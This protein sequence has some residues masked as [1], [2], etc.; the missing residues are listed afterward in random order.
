MQQHEQQSPTGYIKHL[1]RIQNCIVNILHKEDMWHVNVY[2]IFKSSSIT[3]HENKCSCNI[4]CSIQV[5][6]NTKHRAKIADITNKIRNCSNNMHFKSNCA[7]HLCNI[8][9]HSVARESF[10]VLHKQQR[11]I[12]YFFNNS[13]CLLTAATDAESGS[14]LGLSSGGQKCDH[15]DWTVFPLEY[16]KAVHAVWPD[17]S[18]AVSFR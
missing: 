10:A 15:P 14:G 18:K 13:I 1:R 12:I 5:Q 2:H 7:V 16:W 17:M 6:Y 3:I 4:L 11:I 8:V 9:H